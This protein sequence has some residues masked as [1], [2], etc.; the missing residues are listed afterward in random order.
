[1]LEAKDIQRMAK[2]G[3]GYNVDFKRS[4]PSKV[5]E[6]SEEVCGFANSSGGFLLIGVNDANLIVGT[7][8]D[9]SK[10]STKVIYI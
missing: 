10:R 8:I 1:M 3:E 4:V 7:E 5:R 9:N 2:E 6:L